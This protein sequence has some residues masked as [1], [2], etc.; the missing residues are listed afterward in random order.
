MKS[1]IQ[2]EA[3]YYEKSEVLTATYMAD[4]IPDTSFGFLKSERLRP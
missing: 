3:Y 1:E 4:I 2:W